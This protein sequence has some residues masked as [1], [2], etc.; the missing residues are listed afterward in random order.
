[1]SSTLR[2]EASRRRLNWQFRVM[3]AAL[4]ADG[5]DRREG[6]VTRQRPLFFVNQ[7]L[8]GTLISGKVIESVNLAVGVCSR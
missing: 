3:S 2:I 1:M 4:H 5:A 6:G 7:D 8:R